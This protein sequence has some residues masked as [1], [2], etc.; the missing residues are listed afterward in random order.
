MDFIADENISQKI[1]SKLKD[2]GHSVRQIVSNGTVLHD[3]E[4]LR[5]VKETKAVLLTT[6]PEVAQM[7]FNDPEVT[8][9]VALIRLEGKSGREKAE[10]VSQAFLK[11]KSGF[12][13]VLIEVSTDGIKFK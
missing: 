2:D 8:Q 11:A 5:I 12:M 1:V 13:K 7:I 4:L 6:V 9:D 10:L 3:D